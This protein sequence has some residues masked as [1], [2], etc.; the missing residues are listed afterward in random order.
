[1]IEGGAKVATAFLKAGLVDQLHAYIEPMF[2]GALGRSGVNDLPVTT[3]DQT[4]R[5]HTDL[6]EQLGNTVFIQAT[7]R[8]KL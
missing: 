7:R 6:T 4:E 8:E 5:W 1:L 3:L 2:L